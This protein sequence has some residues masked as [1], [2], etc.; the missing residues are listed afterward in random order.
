MS[1]TPRTFPVP[2]LTALPI[3]TI[4]NAIPKA[5]PNWIR[6][7]GAGTLFDM[8]SNLVDQLHLAVVADTKSPIQSFVS[9]QRLPVVTDVGASTQPEVHSKRR[10]GRDGE[11]L[12]E[13]VGEAKVV[14]QID[15]VSGE[16]SLEAVRDEPVIG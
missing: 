8:R 15:A 6:R 5:P 14:S 12:D 3:V 1:T 9:V 4:Q 2:S 13:S 11:V 10:S 16:V 7:I